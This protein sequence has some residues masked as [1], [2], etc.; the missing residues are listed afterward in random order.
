MVRS[1]VVLENSRL[2]LSLGKVGIVGGKSVRDGAKTLGSMWCRKWCN[3]DVQEGWNQVPLS[4][5]SG[6]S[7]K[8][9]RSVWCLK[10]VEIIGCSRGGIRA[11]LKMVWQSLKAVRW[12]W[13]LSQDGGDQGRSLGKGG[14]DGGLE[15]SVGRSGSSEIGQGAQSGVMQVR[16]W[17]G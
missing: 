14:L 2:G 3:P 1:G 16:C 8:A 9:V 4:G 10:M 7:W 13:V 17:E 11:V 6:W 15:E 12:V 5:R